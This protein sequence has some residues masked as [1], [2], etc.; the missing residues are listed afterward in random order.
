M[1]VMPVNKVVDPKRKIGKMEGQGVADPP[2]MHI[3]SKK[4]DS[5]AMFSYKSDGIRT[6]VCCL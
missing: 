4:H 6:R 2:K 3:K 5:I 1:P